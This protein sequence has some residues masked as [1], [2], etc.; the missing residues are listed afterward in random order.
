MA[1]IH[2][3]ELSWGSE[4]PTF[5]RYGLHKGP[6]AILPERLGQ[7]SQGPPPC[8]V[9]RVFIYLWHTSHFPLSKTKLF[10]P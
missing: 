5:S 9:R 1:S 6:L 2:T 3:G 7:T 10:E 4:Q 8:I